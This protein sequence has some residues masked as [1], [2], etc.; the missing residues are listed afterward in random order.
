MEA[1]IARLEAKL[2]AVL[3]KLATDGTGGP[4]YGEL[5]T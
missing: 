5:C 4:I 2:E 1:G 3:E